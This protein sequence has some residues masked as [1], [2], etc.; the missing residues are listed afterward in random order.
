L[1]DARDSFLLKRPIPQAPVVQTVRIC[2]NRSARHEVYERA[3]R[4]CPGCYPAD[5]LPVPD[6]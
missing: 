5:R 2:S 6:L 3:A 1:M 4:S